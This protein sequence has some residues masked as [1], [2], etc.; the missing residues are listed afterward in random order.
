MTYL[1]NS[2]PQLI[3]E[4]AIA[5]I[6][7]SGFHLASIDTIA[8]R[9][10]ISPALIYRH[11]SGKQEIISAIVSGYETETNK[12]IELA[13]AQADGRLA[14]RVMFGLDQPLDQEVIG[15]G[16][17][18]VEIMAEATRNASIA[19]ILVRSD[20]ARRTALLKIL[21]RSRSGQAVS[22]AVA[23]AEAEILLA[24]ADG[25]EARAAFAKPEELQSLTA[26][27]RAIDALFTRFLGLPETI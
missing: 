11:F 22:K 20:E 13:L 26:L 23:L 3:L 4:A 18:H 24:L 17:L 7:E 1:P 8:K 21:K 14:L 25:L 2:R 6:I 12:V 16:V 5:C 9:A 15:Q 19:A 10:K 27:A